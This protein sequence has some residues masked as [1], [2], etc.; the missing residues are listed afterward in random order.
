MFSESEVL[1]LFSLLLLKK[2]RV[3]SNRKTR[4]NEGKVKRKKRAVTAVC[5]H[6]N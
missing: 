3:K 2:Q 1:G 6:C 4:A 5:F